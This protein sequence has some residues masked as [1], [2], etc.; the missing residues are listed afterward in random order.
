V[1]P[2]LAMSLTVE[3]F[4]ALSSL[5]SLVLG[6]NV[7]EDD[8]LRWFSQ[9]IAFNQPNFGLRQ[10][11]GGPC[12]VLAV[13]QAELIKELFFMNAC[14]QVGDEIPS[15]S[16]FERNK[17]LAKALWNILWRCRSNDSISLV[18]SKPSSYSL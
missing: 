3:N 13:L 7:M 15:I 17:S 14:D 5:Q 11:H 8:L 18:S 10:G 2:N 1:I 12:G 9:E 6:S 4:V 16:E